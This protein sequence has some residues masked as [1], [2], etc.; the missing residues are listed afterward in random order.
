[1]NATFGSSGDLNVAFMAVQ[2]QNVGCS[3]P[4]RTLA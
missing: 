2:N 4:R 1:M 3:I